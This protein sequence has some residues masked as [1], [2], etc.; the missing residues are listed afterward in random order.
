MTCTNISPVA[1][2][3]SKW[4]AAWLPI[5]YKLHS[6]RWPVNTYDDEDTIY[7]ISNEYG[8]ARV[9]LSGDSRNL[10]S[11]RVYQNQWISG[12]SL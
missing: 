3:Q 2:Q 10:R 4:V 9:V 1:Y 5:Q 7:T 8:F 11:E 12:R 6:Y